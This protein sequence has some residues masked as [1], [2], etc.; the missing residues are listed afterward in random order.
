VREDEN[1][2]YTRWQAMRLNQLGLC[3]SL[4]LTYSVATLGFSINLLVQREYE[5][6]SCFAKAF[7]LFSVVLGLFSI[8]LGAAACLTRLEDFR[9]T[10]RVARHH[11]KPEMKEEVARWREKY[12]RLGEW[13]WR[14]FRGQ[15]VTFGS[16]ALGLVLS[17]GVTYWH[18]L[19]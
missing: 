6:T 13:T 2:P 10:A 15:L 12:K 8:S 19:T 4:F 18:R 9:T 11:C 17:L 1:Y 16:Q 14:L 3:I 7:L 5:I